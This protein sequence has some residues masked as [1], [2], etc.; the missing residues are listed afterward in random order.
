[1]TYT[2]KLNDYVRWKSPHTELEGWVYFVDR[3][4]CTIEIGVKDKC[5]ENIRDCP[6]H[7]KTTCLVVCYPQFWPELEYIKSRDPEDHYKSQQY[8]Y[9]DPQ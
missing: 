1:M 4:Y 7:K 5:E 9:S 8:R 6:I 3:E 2:P